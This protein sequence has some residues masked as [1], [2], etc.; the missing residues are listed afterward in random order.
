MLISIVNVPNKIDGNQLFDYAKISR[1]PKSRVQ[2]IVF[3][4]IFKGIPIY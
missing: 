1:N 2:H 4:C 3:K